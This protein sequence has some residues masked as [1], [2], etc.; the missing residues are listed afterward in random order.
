M[1]TRAEVYAVNEIIKLKLVSHM[2]MPEFRQSPKLLIP[3]H[4]AIHALALTNNG[5]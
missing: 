1:A 5:Q 2:F 4:G 3:Q